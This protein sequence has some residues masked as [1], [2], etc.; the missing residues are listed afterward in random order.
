M[1]GPASTSRE[2]VENLR[3]P[4]V[5][6]PFVR[7]YCSN[8]EAYPWRI[9]LIFATLHLCV[10]TTLPSVI[11]TNPFMD[12]I[13]GLAYGHQWKL[14]YDKHPPLAWRFVELT[15]D[16]FKNNKSF[17]LISQFAIIA[18]LAIVFSAV[19]RVLTASAAF[20]TILILDGLHYFHF[21]GVKFNQD[22]C[23]LPLWALAGYS[24]WRALR[25]NSLRAWM[26]LAFSLAGAFWCK[27]F[28]IV[29]AIPMVLFLLL[30]RDARARL[31]TAKPYLAAAA[32]LLV[33]A[34]HLL[35]I[36]DN[37]FV[38]L[39]Y[40]S[41]RAAD[42][43]GAI[44]HLKFPLQFAAWQA[45]YLLPS[46]AIALPLMVRRGTTR[47]IAIDGFDR[48]II[49]LLA[50]GPAAT[51]FFISLIT[52][53]GV[54]PMWAYPLWLF[55]G[56]FIVVAAKSAVDCSKLTQITF[57]WAICFVAFA[58]AFSLNYGVFI[59]HKRD[60]RFQAFFPGKQLAQEITRRYSAIAGKPPAYVIGSIWIGGNV[61]YFAPGRPELLIDGIPARAPWID[62]SDL[63]RK[64]AVVVWTGPHSDDG[65]GHATT[66]LP[67]LV[68]RVA[69]NAQVQQP[70]TLKYGRGG[71]TAEVGWAI[72]RPEN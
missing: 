58:I 68:R 47:D 37:D 6:S 43:T 18:S 55:L 72:L 17:F 12:V 42:N 23:Q 60:P 5:F 34:P 54:L 33:L 56:V 3:S 71:G 8:I 35:W 70:F 15:H 10:W 40:V 9:F 28:A 32:F 44:D 48:R 59:Q 63:K 46:F 67:P 65:L 21:T 11:F 27:Y 7:A 36:W 64:G 2:V 69:G 62:L 26:L 16:L 57:L 45:W 38:S 29:L 30:N 52:G 66:E 51:L 20:V 49:T 25:D 41:V 22:V 1:R 4:Q 31:A 24:Y 61:A 14:G 19:R 13:E 53:R 50:L 39:K